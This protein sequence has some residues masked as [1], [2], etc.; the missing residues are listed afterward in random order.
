MPYSSVITLNGL[1]IAT[2]I[3][4]KSDGLRGKSTCSL[5]SG[6]CKFDPGEYVVPVS[7]RMIDVGLIE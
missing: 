5:I 7:L 1:A 6:G 3:I 2:A 4:S